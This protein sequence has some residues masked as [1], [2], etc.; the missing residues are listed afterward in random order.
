MQKAENLYRK[1]LADSV[2]GVNIKDLGLGK[3]EQTNKET[4]P[5]EGRMSIQTIDGRRIVVIDTDQDIFEGV[6]R[7]EYG[8]VAREYMK[9]HFRGETVDGVRFTSTSEREYT[10]SKD[11]NKTMQKSPSIYG[12]KMRASTELD[13][14]VKTSKFIRHEVARHPHNYNKDGYNRYTTRFILDGHHFEGEMLV[15]LSDGKSMFYDI[16]S[17]KE[18]E[19]DRQNRSKPAGVESASNQSIA[20]SDASVNS[21]RKKSE[22]DSE[23]RADLKESVRTLSEYTEQEVKSIETDK[24]TRVA[25]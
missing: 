21:L 12:A 11:T 17:I 18:K 1:A 19:A 9:K 16:V 23:E 14:L 8:K 22:K 20:Q 13:N 7:S 2:G 25:R 3:E 24:R 5:V 15:A 6:P 4:A 10:M